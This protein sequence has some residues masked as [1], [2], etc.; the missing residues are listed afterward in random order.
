MSEKVPFLVSNPFL[1]GTL[2][3]G[4]VRS[5][6]DAL[7]SP[8]TRLTVSSPTLSP[9][10]G[11]VGGGYLVTHT[12][13]NS[14]VSKSELE[15]LSLEN[16][17]NPPRE[18]EKYIITKDLTDI[19]RQ[20]KQAN[21]QAL[22]YLLNDLSTSIR[23]KLTLE[24]VED[25]F[26]K[27]GL[28]LFYN[29][30]YD[31]IEHVPLFLQERF[32][33]AL[34]TVRNDS[35]LTYAENK[36]TSY[37]A[38]LKRY[39][40]YV[41]VVREN[42]SS[43]VPLETRYSNG[44]REKVQ[45]RMKGLAY[46]YRRGSSVLATFTLDP[47]LY[48]NDKVRMWTEIRSEVNV[49]LTKV[50]RYLNRRGLPMPPYLCTIEAMKQPRSCGNPHVHIVFV[51]VGR[52]MDWRVLRKLWGVGNIWINRSWKGEKVRNPVMYASKYITK[53]YTETTADNVLTQSLVWL[54]NV[55]SFSSSQGLVVP[56]HPQ[57]VGD[58]T[59]DYIAVCSP[60]ETIFDD[61]ALIENRV[62]GGYV[63]DIPPPFTNH[64][65]HEGVIR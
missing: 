48:G 3:G 1:G 13:Y 29:G 39:R 25:H 36:F 24:L 18:Y 15:P 31:E 38:N 27:N 30:N 43:F 49:F 20:T 19:N 4:T 23:R 2:E 50:R 47:K 12:T 32:T 64:V 42:Q 62:N 26:N 9:L 7:A 45:R 46:Q 57:G 63:G 41:H 33:N 40:R 11:G 44:Y 53:T 52:L 17:A 10:E 22:D 59:A 16:R 60:Q 54:F 56:L 21:I 51:G 34:V 8:L 35:L 14:N 65:S 6:S 61:F 5:H 58:W 28:D 55:K 37:I